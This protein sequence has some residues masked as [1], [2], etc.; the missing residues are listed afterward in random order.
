MLIAF[1]V[2][3]SSDELVVNLLG[4]FYGGQDWEPRSHDE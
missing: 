1:E 2:D 3:E 4:V